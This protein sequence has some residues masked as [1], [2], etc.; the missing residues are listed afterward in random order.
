MSD[1]EESNA[2]K[3]PGRRS[4]ASKLATKGRGTPSTGPGRSKTPA[5]TEQVVEIDDDD[6]FEEPEANNSKPKPKRKRA[7]PANTTTKSP[8]APG[9]VRFPAELP[10]NLA[11]LFRQYFIANNSNTVPIDIYY[12]QVPWVHR[13]H[14]AKNKKDATVAAYY[15]GPTGQ[16]VEVR[17]FSLSW[18]L[19]VPGGRNSQ[20]LLVASGQPFAEPV[21]LARIIKGSSEFRIWRGVDDN[22]YE[23][24]V[25]VKKARV[26]N[27]TVPSTNTPPPETPTPMP[28]PKLPALPAPAPTHGKR[29][30]D[31]TPTSQYPD[32]QDEDEDY[33]GDVAYENALVPANRQLARYTVPPILSP[34][35]DNISRN[36]VFRFLG[37]HR[38]ERIRNLY[39]CATFAKL[40]TNAI[41]AGVLVENDPIQ[42]LNCEWCVSNGAHSIKMVADDQDFDDLMTEITDDRGWDLADAQCVIDVTRKTW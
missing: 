13:M 29:K 31:S 35:A 23:Q 32:F 19:D 14:N 30:R 16:E 33:T 9:Q 41:V 6:I 34:V 39:Q 37:S 24:A 7:T 22:P 40:F 10:G 28:P 27:H 2:P 21:I 36:I 20:R 12:M 15:H 38:Q 5:R 42:I 25:V 17:G 26:I 4:Q 3:G 11:D 8:E 1:V 18:M